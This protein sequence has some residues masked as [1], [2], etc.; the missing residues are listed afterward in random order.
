MDINPR[1]LKT[2]QCWRSASAL[3]GSC[4]LRCCPYYYQKGKEGVV[5]VNVNSKLSTAWASKPSWGS[6]SVYQRLY[7]RSVR[8]IT[9]II[10]ELFS[11]IFHTTH[12]EVLLQKTY[13]NM[14]R[15]LPGW[16][17]PWPKCKCCRWYLVQ[18]QL[19]LVRIILLL[20][21]VLAPLQ[22]ITNTLS[23][24]TVTEGRHI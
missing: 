11:M 7:G 14:G 18:Q 17:H 1:I 13:D 21:K 3:Y 6:D 22:A 9:R 2:C 20:Y 24:S 5:E 16:S 8:Q 4:A 10:S 23:V 15:I 12:G 19:L